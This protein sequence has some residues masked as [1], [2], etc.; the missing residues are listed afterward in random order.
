MLVMTR[1]LAES[2]TLNDEIKITV[3]EIRDD[4][5][6][7]GI[8]GPNDLLIHWQESEDAN[9]HMHKEEKPQA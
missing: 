2:F 9:Q 6:R 5:V 8:E 1:K 4:G 3:I 7:I